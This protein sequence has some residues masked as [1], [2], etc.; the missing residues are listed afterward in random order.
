M[1]A[2]YLPGHNLQFMFCR[3]LPQQIAHTKRY[4]TRQHCLSILWYPHQMDFQVRLR[5][6][7]QPVMPHATTLH[8]IL[9]RLKARGF[10][11]PR[12]GH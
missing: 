6:R 11:H 1:V 8:Q 3:N 2:C 7:S 4:L 5:V 9:L 12:W 10:H